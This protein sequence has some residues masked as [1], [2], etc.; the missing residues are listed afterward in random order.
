MMRTDDL[1]AFGWTSAVLGMATLFRFLHQL[2]A[3][4]PISFSREPSAKTTDLRL[5]QYEN[6]YYPMLCTLAGICTFVRS[7]Y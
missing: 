6:A 2:K 4:F 3:S 1:K 5:G 7:I